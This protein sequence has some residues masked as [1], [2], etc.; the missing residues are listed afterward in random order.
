[1]QPMTRIPAMTSEAT[2]SIGSNNRIVY[3]HGRD[4]HATYLKSHRLKQRLIGFV[5]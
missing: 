4:A 5:L 1:M 2:A 3:A